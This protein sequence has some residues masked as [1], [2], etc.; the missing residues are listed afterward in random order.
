M[1][2]M[3]TYTVCCKLATTPAIA[4]A[5]KETSQRYA[6]ACNYLLKASIDQKTSNA[7]TLHK[8]CYA[9]VRE[10]FGLSAN[11][12][13][14]AIRRVCAMRT[15]LKGKRK[16]P[17]LFKPKS[18]DYDAR[19]FSYKQQDKTIS[20]KTIRGRIKCPLILGKYQQ[21]ALTDQNP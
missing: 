10:I 21:K 20:L 8:L 4:E 12:T 1:Y 18:I 17:K 5:L 15:R 13:V 9:K 11:L 3:K 6:D 14:R 7:I 16:S 2:N 19:I